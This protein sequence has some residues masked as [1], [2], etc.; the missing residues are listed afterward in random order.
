MVRSHS[1]VGE[2]M[3][4]TFSNTVGEAF[5]KS[6]K[7]FLQMEMQKDQKSTKEE[8]VILFFS[9]DIVNSSSFKIK[10]PQNWAS[11][12]TDIIKQIK[13]E[14]ASS[15]SI[16][17][18]HNAHLWRILGDE[19]IFTIAITSL[20]Q[21]N[22]IIVEIYSVLQ[23]LISHLH[24]GSFFP[25]SKKES[26]FNLNDVK[27]LS[28]QASAWIALINIAQN[29][30]LSNS[31]N[32]KTEYMVTDDYT[33]TEYLGNDIDAGFRISKYT[34]RSR[35][36]VSFELATLLQ[37]Q[38]NHIRDNNSQLIILDYVQL[39]GIWNERLYPIIWYY[40]E[41][42]S[43]K[44][45]LESLTYD[46]GLH[47][48]L[49]QNYIQRTQ[50]NFLS[51]LTDPQKMYAIQT[52]IPQLKKDVHLEDKIQKMINTIEN[53]SP[54]KNNRIMEPAHSNR[55]ELHCAAVC[56]NKNNKKIL[57]FKRKESNNSYPNK[58]EFGCAR[59]T[60]QST[61]KDTLISSYKEF[62]NLNI[63]PILTINRTDNTPIPLEI[64]GLNDEE[65][66][67]KGIIFVAFI[68]V[69]ENITNNF[70]TAKHDK[71]DWISKEEIENFQ[72][73]AVPNFK[74]TLKESFDFIG[75]YNKKKERVNE[76]LDD[77]NESNGEILA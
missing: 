46:E 74:E 26:N 11:I 61:I 68:D 63:K 7:T 48:E 3:K 36:V 17:Q 39:K 60:Q 42:I 24:D 29:A 43:N 20:D 75:R 44:S 54:S 67:Y 73:L 18:L 71:A 55:P 6:I 52:A 58:W 32:I 64:Y 51:K 22:E 77:K 65:R 59:A 19:L 47:N 2:S 13:E 31:E 1:M 16:T 30:A 66:S 34:K 37:S 53:S 8:E 38:Y 41:K 12:I 56:Y 28:L 9:Y 14:I 4:K 5:K 69:A 49:I 45:F 15:N 72:E 40:N 50:G 23:N 10:H 76:R 21:I 35:L 62:F 25:N 70:K 27:E 33:L 57:I